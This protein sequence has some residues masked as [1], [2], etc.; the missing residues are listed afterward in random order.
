MSALNLGQHVA[1]LI[2]IHATPFGFEGIPVQANKVVELDSRKPGVLSFSLVESPDAC[3]VRI[4]RPQ[5]LLHRVI[6][7]PDVPY[8]KFIQQAGAESMA[9][10]KGI[11]L[12]LHFL[13]K[14]AIERNRAA[15]VISE[16]VET[17]R[18]NEGIALAHAVID[19]DIKLVDSG[20]IRWRKDKIP[21]GGVGKGNKL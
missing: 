2:S 14:S 1:R 19:P 5:S 18:V 7:V 3:F 4:I 10:P 15:G 11:A 12:A 13:G 8:L 20:R 17:L 6:A 9:F 21:P 16:P